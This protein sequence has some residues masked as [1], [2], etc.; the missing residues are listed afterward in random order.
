MEADGKDEE[1]LLVLANWILFFLRVASAFFFLIVLFV[2]GAALL[3]YSRN[4]RQFA[5]R[6]EVKIRRTFAG[7]ED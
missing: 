7:H 1:F 6:V 2:A 5:R 4:L 3:E